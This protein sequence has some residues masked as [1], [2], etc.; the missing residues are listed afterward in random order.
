MASAFQLSGR[1]ALL[2]GL[3]AV[4]VGVGFAYLNGGFTPLGAP[5]MDS[6]ELIAGFIVSA[7]LYQFGTPFFCAAAFFFGIPAR[8]AWSARIGIGLAAVAL[9]PYVFFVRTCSG[10]ITEL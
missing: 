2:A 9:V 1:V 8:S 6:R 10:L 3:I 7:L 4:S 5:R